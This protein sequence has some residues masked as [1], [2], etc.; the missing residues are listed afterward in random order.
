MTLESIRDEVAAI[1]RLRDAL[2]NS[3]AELMISVGQF[4]SERGG[5]RENA[6]RLGFSAVYVSDVVGGRRKISG[7]FI[8]R[9]GRL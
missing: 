5:V 7:E 9:L 6:R 1:N 2:D 4:L 8:E 3:E